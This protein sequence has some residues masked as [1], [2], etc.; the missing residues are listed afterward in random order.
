MARLVLLSFDSNADAELIVRQLQD[1]GVLPGD[2]TVEWVLGKPT[3]SCECA[4]KADPVAR[5][6]RRGVGRTSKDAFTKGRKLGWWLHAACGRPTR[7]VVERF[8]TNLTNGHY[9]LLPEIL[10]D[11][12]RVPN[13]T[14][15]YAGDWVENQRTRRR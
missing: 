14:R 3:R 7:M 5:R 15:M 12:E 4:L 8:T 11:P 6:K 10:G 2:P 1:G 13:D 9:D